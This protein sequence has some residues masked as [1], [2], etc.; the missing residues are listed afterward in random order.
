[1]L[2]HFFVPNTVEQITV[3]E[4]LFKRFLGSYLSK[5][6]YGVN[7]FLQDTDLNI[8]IKFVTFSSLL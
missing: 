6:S 7:Q 8:N 2:Y 3:L 5:K 1:M 4:R